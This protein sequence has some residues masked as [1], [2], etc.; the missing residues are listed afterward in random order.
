MSSYTELHENQT[1]GLDADTT[2]LMDGVF[3]ISFFFYFVKHV[4]KG[5]PN[6]FNS[7]HIK[8]PPIELHI[9]LRFTSIPN[10]KRLTWLLYYLWLSDWKLPISVAARS[11][12]W[13][14]GRSRAGDCGFESHRGHRCLSVLCCV[15]SG[16]SLCD[17]L[18][19]RPEKS[20]LLW[21]VVVWSTN[22]K[23]E[24]M[25]RVGPQRHRGGTGSYIY[26]VLQKNRR[27]VPIPHI[28]NPCKVTLPLHKFTRLPCIRY[29]YLRSYRHDE[30]PVTTNSIMSKKIVKIGQSV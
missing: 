21:C 10:I 29:C 20:Y 16:R 8:E 5:V 2:S 7:W 30:V 28:N 26:Y 18:I 23:N 1:H 3:A 17:G 14:Y 6:I 9:C 11:K 24:A 15:L 19:T 13:I 27:S 12:A 22:L 25:A 4:Y